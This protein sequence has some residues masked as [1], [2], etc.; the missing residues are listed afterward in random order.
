MKGMLV[1]PLSTA[2]VSDEFTQELHMP[3]GPQMLDD[4]EEP[5]PARPATLKDPG[6]PRSNRDGTAQSD[7]HFP[8]QPW[9][10]MCVESRGRDSPH[11]E[12]S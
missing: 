6:T 8:S 7:A 3:I 5:M 2:G 9:C 12:E 10:K 4:V 1:A 11:R